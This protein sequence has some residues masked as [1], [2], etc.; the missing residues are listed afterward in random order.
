VWQSG[1]AGEVNKHDRKNFLVQSLSSLEHL[2]AHFHHNH[3]QQI[4]ASR[5]GSNRTLAKKKSLVDHSRRNNLLKSMVSSHE[6]IIK[7][8]YILGFLQIVYHQNAS[9]PWF[10]SFDAV[11]SFTVTI[12]HK[13]QHI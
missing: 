13:V 12:S 4:T 1:S 9:D 10:P 7:I 2:T 6:H 11:K 5:S 8:H 3:H